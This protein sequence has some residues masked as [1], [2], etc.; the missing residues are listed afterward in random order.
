MLC[1]LFDIWNEQKS[2][3][4][5]SIQYSKLVKVW[6]ISVCHT[7]DSLYEDTDDD[8]EFRRRSSSD[9]LEVTPN[10]VDE[11]KEHLIKG[12]LLFIVA[13]A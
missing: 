8:M 7:N 3:N 9:P 10:L 13:F 4:L 6:L 2:L 12:L 11:I 5:H 1:N